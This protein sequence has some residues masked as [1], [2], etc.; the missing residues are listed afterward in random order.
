MSADECDILFARLRKTLDDVLMQADVR[1]AVRDKA[2][3]DEFA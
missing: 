3:A 2:S 1:A